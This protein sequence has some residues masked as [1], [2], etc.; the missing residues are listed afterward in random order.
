MNFYGASA[1]SIDKSGSNFTV[2]IHRVLSK[3]TQFEPRLKLI[4]QGLDLV[5]K[6]YNGA[7]APTRK[8]VK[9]IHKR[10]DSYKLH[11]PDK[12]EDVPLLGQLQR[13]NF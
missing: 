2:F 4:V 1:G 5:Q 9:Q 3:T 12:L 13:G 11:F 7:L 10:V 6:W 8:C